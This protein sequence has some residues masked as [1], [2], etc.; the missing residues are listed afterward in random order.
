MCVK[1]REIPDEWC[2]P[3]ML[4]F[5]RKTSDEQLLTITHL[6]CTDMSQEGMAFYMERKLIDFEVRAF[7]LDYMD[8]MGTYN[9]VV[10][11]RTFIERL[12]TI[13]RIPVSVWL[14]NDFAIFEIRVSKILF[15]NIYSQNLFSKSAF[16]YLFRK[17]APQT[18]APENYVPNMRFQNLAFQNGLKTV[19]CKTAATECVGFL[20]IRRILQEHSHKMLRT[21]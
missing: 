18:F 19:P 15:P 21:T 7:W 10:K 14:S 11:L 16:A 4:W 20:L 12:N 5:A 6:D 1:T 2:T 17:G 13:Q 8:S 3:L 9:K